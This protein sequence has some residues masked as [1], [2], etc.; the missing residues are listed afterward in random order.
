MKAQFDQKLLSSFYLW[1][2]DRVVRYGEAVESDISQTFYYSENSVDL[3]SDKVAYYSPDRQFVSLGHDV[4][5]GVYI[6][7]GDF[8]DD[9]VFTEQQPNTSIG[10]MIDNDQGRV[11][12][13]SSVGT[14]LSISG[15]FSRKT[16]NTYITNESEEELLLNTDF[17]LADQ[18]DQTFLES[19][20][21]FSSLNY[22]LP[23]AFISYNSSVNN[24]F[25]FGGM[26][27][28]RSNIRTVVIA[29]DNYV[30]DSA[31]SLFRDSTETCVPIL[32]YAEFPYGEYFHLK[33]NPYLYETIYQQKMD[34]KAQYAFIEKINVSKLY[35]TSSS[36]LN[37]PR[38][39][40]IGFI[41]FTLS[42]PRM[43]KIELG[44]P[45]V[46]TTQP[47]APLDEVQVTITGPKNRYFFI[48]P[49]Y[50]P[51]NRGFTSWQIKD[52]AN[53]P[54]THL[55]FAFSDT[56]SQRPDEII[57]TAGMKLATFYKLSDKEIYC[58][59]EKSFALFDLDPTVTITFTIQ[60]F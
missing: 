46:V 40:R 18:D 32:D 15:N 37:L 17:L 28:T 50:F 55:S 38:N 31:L 41:D 8:G 30:L 35:D 44:K 47:P 23:A 19:I 1:F 21:G 7:G 16:L 11:I 20:T 14:G 57:S 6:K 56:T 36:A 13:N 58:E 42:T 33:K 24:P 34:V 49:V 25:A 22:T 59:L 10:L 51:E 27:D 48:D 29:N 3:P 4:P 43:P 9:Y 52:N 60:Y 39:M 54:S 2:D 45:T 53:L 12:M 5:S 26:Q